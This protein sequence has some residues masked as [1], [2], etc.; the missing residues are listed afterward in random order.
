MRCTVGP[1]TH[2][3]PLPP[4]ACPLS[5]RIG[6][7]QHLIH[8]TRRELARL[9]ESGSR[10]RDLYNDCHAT[11]HACQLEI[12]VLREERTIRSEGRS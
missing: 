1:F 10:D 4:Y 2:A 5:R 3:A 11:I 6:A 8:E 12:E 9:R 7:L